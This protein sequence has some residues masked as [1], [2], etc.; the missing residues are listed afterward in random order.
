[1]PTSYSLIQK[2][3]CSDDVA[4]KKEVKDSFKVNNVNLKHNSKM[5][6]ILKL[7]GCYV[8]PMPIS[9]I[10]LSTVGDDIYVCV[11]CGSLVQEDKILFVYIVPI[12]GEKIG[13]PS[14]VGHTSVI[15][16]MAKDA[17]CGNVR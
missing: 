9:A 13:C 10:L 4:Q 17:S 5:Q 2:V 7:V 12:T 3:S 8:H 14:F 16:P 6:D 15:L 11:L 1:M